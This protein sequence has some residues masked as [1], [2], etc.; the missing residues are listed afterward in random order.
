MFVT[1]FHNHRIQRFSL[2]G[3]F[4]LEWGQN[5]NAEGDF[6]NPCG[7][8]VDCDRDEVYVTETTSHR[9]QVFDSNGNYIR[10]FGRPG[11]GNGELYVPADIATDPIQKDTVFVADAGHNR[12][13]VFD[14][15]GVYQYQWGKSGNQPGPG[16]GEFH[17]PVSLAFNTQG[18]LYVVD[19]DNERIQYFT[20][21]GKYL[22]QWGML[23]QKDG[24]FV[25][26]YGLKVDSSD[27]VYVSSGHKVQKFDSSGNFITSF[28]YPGS[29][30]GE[31]VGPIGIATI[32]G[33]LIK[34]VYVY[35]ASS[36]N[37]RIVIFQQEPEISVLP[38]VPH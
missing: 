29:G 23:G 9:I 11:Q 8:C 27:N 25:G 14:L 17:Y 31:L 38:Y 15:K 24:Q 13:Q 1:D 5:G 32:E 4:Q 2:A 6:T 20:S 30:D 26:P 19:S 35:V 10:K 34:R 28:G 7:I 16:N 22:N 33:G 18:V 3:K 37:H 21:D 36:W 12:I